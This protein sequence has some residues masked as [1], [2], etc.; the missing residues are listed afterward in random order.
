MMWMLGRKTADTVMKKLMR[1]MSAWA[2][3][4]LFSNCSTGFNRE[5]QRS[6]VDGKDRAGKDI[7]GIWQGTWR[8]EVNGHSGKLRC[9]VSR[10]HAA[11]GACEKDSYRFHYQAS[12]MKLLSA[13]YAVK[14][15]V[16]ETKEGF[17]FT[18]E[19]SIPGIGGGLYH[20]QGKGTP[21][22]LKA[23]Y[24]SKFDEGAFELKR[25]PGL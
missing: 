15:H 1:R 9:I 22:Q 14:H 24:R 18:G 13:T 4:L 23:T 16:V 8:S 21:A 7:T 5:W 19:Q 20:Y 25:P 6:L 2:V 12:F 11:P 10:E 17:S 3:I